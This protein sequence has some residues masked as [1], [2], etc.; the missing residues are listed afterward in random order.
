MANMTMDAKEFGVSGKLIGEI[1]LRDNQHDCAQ[2]LFFENGGQ[3][4]AESWNYSQC[5]DGKALVLVQFND[6]QLRELRDAITTK[7]IPLE[8]RRRRFR[9][10]NRPWSG[11]SV[12]FKLKKAGRNCGHGEGAWGDD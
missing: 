6:D 7:L 11:K 9:L 8:R 1:T 2:F 12:C 4:N 3:V 10:L 5:D